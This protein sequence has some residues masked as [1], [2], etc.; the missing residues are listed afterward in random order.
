[1]IQVKISILKVIE[2]NKMVAGNKFN[3]TKHQ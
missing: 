3:L 1:M 2:I